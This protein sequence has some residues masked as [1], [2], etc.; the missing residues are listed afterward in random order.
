[1][2]QKKS[3]VIAVS[4]QRISDEALAAKTNRSWEAWFELL[5]TWG[6]TAHSHAEIARRLV[7]EH[8]IDE[9]WAQ[10]ITVGYEQARGMR[11]P[12]Q[13]ADGTFAANASKTIGMVPNA[14]FDAFADAAKRAQWLPDATIV[15]TTVSP[16][17]SFRAECEDGTRIAV[18]LTDKGDARTGVSVQ[19]EKLPD[20]DAAA[21][22][23]AYWRERL[24]DLK[25]MLEG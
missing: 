1:M 8:A 17:K 10:T 5:D 18:W 2:S 22:K 25:T 12:G 6:G 24:D 15:P 14:V 23:K 4:G 9:W 7:E 11:K 19:H 21:A 3:Q 20:G 16:P 13:S